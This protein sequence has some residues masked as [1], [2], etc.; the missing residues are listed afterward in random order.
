MRTVVINLFTDQGIGLWPVSRIQI[1]SFRIRIRSIPS[2]SSYRFSILLK[3]LETYEIWIAK[4][5]M[6]NFQH[7]KYNLW[8]KSNL[9]FVENSLIFKIVTY[10][11]PELSFNVNTDPDLQVILRDRYKLQSFRSERIW[12]SQHWL[13]QR[14]WKKISQQ[15]LSLSSFVKIMQR[16]PF[17]FWS[18]CWWFCNKTEFCLITSH[19]VRSTSPWS[20]CIYYVT[21]NQKLG[22][23][24]NFSAAW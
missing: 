11:D 18:Q 20:G 1:D 6:Y 17:S 16:Y 10:L 19:L 14:L 4:L 8:C 3:L 9:L 5:E 7:T 22:Y 2:G 13:S 23:R 24:N 15:M 12:N 21:K